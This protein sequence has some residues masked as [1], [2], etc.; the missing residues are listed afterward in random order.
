MA[1]FPATL[2]ADYPITERPRVFRVAINTHNDGTEQRV[3][4]SP[5]R[6]PTFAL[7]FQGLAEANR[8]ELLTHYAGQEGEL[9]AFDWVHPE[10]AATLLVRYAG[11]PELTLE[12]LNFWSARVDF[13]VV[14]A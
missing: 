8:D 2:K 9:V 10:T 13:A 6:P 11:P 7:S 4:L 5:G 3:L 1:D 12:G 14:T